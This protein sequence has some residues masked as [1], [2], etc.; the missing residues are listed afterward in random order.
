M[1]SEPSLSAFERFLLWRPFQENAIL[2][3]C[4]LY[5]GVHCSTSKTTAYNGLDMHEPT[6]RLSD[7]PLVDPLDVEV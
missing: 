6:L 2:P 7:L 5:G 3:L 4:V 1:H